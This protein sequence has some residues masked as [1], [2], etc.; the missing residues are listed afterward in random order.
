M[1]FGRLQRRFSWKTRKGAA[2]R[3]RVKR[4]VLILAL[5]SL[6]A[7]AEISRLDAISMIESGNNDFA[8]GGAGEISRY[9][10]KPSIWRRYSQSRAYR[11]VEVS[12]TVAERYLAFL[13]SIFHKRT[14]RPPTDFDRYVLWNGGPSYYAKIGFSANRVHP[15]IRDRARR[16]SNLC[17]MLRERAR[18]A[19]SRAALVSP[20]SP[21]PILGVAGVKAP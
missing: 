15:T 3:H 13:E 11:C 10:I 4:G 14:G 6:S 12:R 18:E 17:A 16:F 2:S 21:Q 8:I 20:D 5:S 19:P 9:Q 1:T 7:Q